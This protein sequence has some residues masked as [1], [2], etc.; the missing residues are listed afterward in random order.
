MQAMERDIKT[1]SPTTVYIQTRS[2]TASQ[3]AS[4]GSSSLCCRMAGRTPEV[5]RTA[6]KLPDIQESPHPA[7]S[8]L[9]PSL[10]PRMFA[11]ILLLPQR[12]KYLELRFF[13]HEFIAC[14]WTTI[15]GLSGIRNYQHH[16]LHTE[17]LNDCWI[18]S[19]SSLVLS[20]CIVNLAG[21]AKDQHKFPYC[22]W[23][24]AALWIIWIN[25]VH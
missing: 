10:W 9:P 6:V 24:N 12:Y 19:F 23:L 5:G 8:L 7:V 18:R 15:C 13:S 20:A 25:N 2:H 21:S 1:R 11:E 3:A 14:Y 16:V 17:S 22:G 4:L